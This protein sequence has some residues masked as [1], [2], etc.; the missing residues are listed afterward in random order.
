MATIGSVHADIVS[1]STALVDSVR[2]IRARMFLT[3]QERAN[4]RASR[5][6]SAVYTASLGGHSYRW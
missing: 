1:L 6:R 2:R 5:G 3:E 4:M